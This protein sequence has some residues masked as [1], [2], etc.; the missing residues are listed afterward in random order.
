ML[1]TSRI[2][3]PS[4]LFGEWL[5]SCLF[6]LLL[7]FLLQ[8]SLLPS[9]VC[10]RVT[11]W[12]CC[13]RNTLLNRRGPIRPPVRSYGGDGGRDILLPFKKGKDQ[14]AKVNTEKIAPSS[15]GLIQCW[16][17]ATYWH[18][19]TF[20]L[21]FSSVAT[22]NMFVTCVSVSTLYIHIREENN[23]ILVLCHRQQ[24]KAL[25][26]CVAGC[27]FVVMA[28]FRTCIHVH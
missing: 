4:W 24:T 16:T 18:I 26:C 19:K 25:L 11:G 12:V 7:C 5:C 15:A 22:D 28:T 21:R 13:F 2:L 9:S 1:G 14:T 27:S 8:Q 20:H 17:P 3:S 10:W 6:G 23:L